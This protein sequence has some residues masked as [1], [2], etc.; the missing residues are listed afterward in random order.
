MALDNSE[1]AIHSLIMSINDRKNEKNKHKFTYIISNVRD[2]VKVDKILK[3][4]N[5]DIIFHAAAHKHLPFME[6]YP[7]EAIKNNILATENIATLAIKNNIKN[8]VFISTDKAV[9]P[10]SL[11]G[12]SKRICERMIMSLSHEQNSTAFKITRF[13]NVLGS[14]GS[15]IPVFEKQIREGKPLTVTH[16]EMVRFFMSIREAAR[17]VIKACTLNDGIIFTLDMGK[18]VKIL[19]LAKNMLKMYGL[20]EKDIPII[21]TGIRE[22]EKLYEEILMDDETLIPSQYK[23]LFIAKDPVKCL[24]PEER[25]IMIDAFDIASLDADKETIKMLMRNYIE[26]YTG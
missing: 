7:E 14:S 1:S 13:G 24:T 12:A 2:Y 19:D 8:F 10:T 6:A 17:L 22:G 20:T 18:P 23:K 11:M 4:E 15:V 21:F 5:P 3:E 26:E 16:P 9:R 25:K